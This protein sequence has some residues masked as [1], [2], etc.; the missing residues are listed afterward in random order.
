ML[1]PYSI[2]IGY[3]FSVALSGLFRVEVQFRVERV[4]LGLSL[5]VKLEGRPQR[6]VGKLRFRCTLLGVNGSGVWLHPDEDDG[7]GNN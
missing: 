6:W 5:T 3:S 4:G 2:M 7:E 1:A